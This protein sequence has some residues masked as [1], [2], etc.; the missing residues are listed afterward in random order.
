MLLAPQ[1]LKFLVIALKQGC[2]SR[3]LRLVIVGVS[4]DIADLQLEVGTLPEVE[5]IDRILIAKLGVHLVIDL[6]ED[7][8]AVA[9]QEH[10]AVVGRVHGIID[11]HDVADVRQLAL[12]VT[13]NGLVILVTAVPQFV[14]CLADG[15]LLTDCGRAV[16]NVPSTLGLKTV[17]EDPHPWQILVGWSREEADHGISVTRLVNLCLPETVIL[18]GVLSPT[19]GDLLQFLGNL[20]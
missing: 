9:E 15:T 7:L 13:G 8:L 12:A 2:G 16:L 4:L 20:S 1:C 11:H 17:G 6:V 18:V 3:E 19:L 5:G 10:L 14:V